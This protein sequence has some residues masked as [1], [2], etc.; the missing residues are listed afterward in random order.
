MNRLAQHPTFSLTN[1]DEMLVGAVA[2]GAF[3]CHKNAT[4]DAELVSHLL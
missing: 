4:S 2:L 1:G 3:V